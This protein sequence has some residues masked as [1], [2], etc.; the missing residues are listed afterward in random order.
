M[1]ILCTTGKR[2]HV[3]CLERGRG[4]GPTQPLVARIQTLNPPL[5]SEGRVQSRV[6]GR[7]MVMKHF[8]DQGIGIHA[9]VLTETVQRSTA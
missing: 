9:Q 3:A 6:R 2:S 4:F 5:P 7:G 8:G 1:E